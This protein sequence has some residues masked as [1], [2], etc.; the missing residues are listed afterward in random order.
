MRNVVLG[1]VLGLTALAVFWFVVELKNVLKSHTDSVTYQ[2][3]NLANARR[4]QRKCLDH[5]LVVSVKRTV[6][7]DYLFRCSEVHWDD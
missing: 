4:F 1:T 5:G 6:T 2:T 3:N 7:G